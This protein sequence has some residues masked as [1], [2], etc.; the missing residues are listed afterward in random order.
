MGAMGATFT[1]ALLSAPPMGATFRI[2][3]LMGAT[4]GVQSNVTP[5]SLNNAMFAKGGTY[6]QL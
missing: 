5:P 1:I 4:L 6:Q 2:V 3:A